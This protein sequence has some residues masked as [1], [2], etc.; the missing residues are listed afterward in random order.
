MACPGADLRRGFCAADA[1]GVGQPPG[2]GRRWPVP[3]AG[4]AIVHCP[5]HFGTSALDTRTE[6]QLLQ[7]V[8][9][10]FRG[11]T[12]LVT[13]HRPGVLDIAHRVY[14]LRGGQ[15]IRQTPGQAKQSMHA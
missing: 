11:K 13:T 8:V 5:G 10:A 3:G 14:A 4:T 9:G 6:G 7:N 2:G 15:A 1:P 12:V